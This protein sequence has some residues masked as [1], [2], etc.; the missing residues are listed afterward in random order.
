MTRFDTKEVTTEHSQYVDELV[1]HFTVIHG[2]L[3]ALGEYVIYY[4]LIPKF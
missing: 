2:R 1:Q 4:G 3:S